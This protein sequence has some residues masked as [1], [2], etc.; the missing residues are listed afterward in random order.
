MSNQHA[1]RLAEVP[2]RADELFVD[3]CSGVAIQGRQDIVQED[4]GGLGIA[5]KR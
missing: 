3:S 2:L 5:G 1:G 4:R